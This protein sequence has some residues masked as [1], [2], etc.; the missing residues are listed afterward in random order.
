MRFMTY[1]IRRGLGADG[2]V[3]VRRIGAV[4]AAARPDVAGLNEVW[5]MTRVSDQPAR[6]ARQLGMDEVFQANVAGRF[7]RF[8]NLVLSCGTIRAGVDLKL[9]SGRE[10]RGALI[11]ETE[12]DGARVVFVTTHLGLTRNWREAQI[13]ELAAELPDDVPLVLAGDFNARFEELAPL[14]ESLQMAPTRLS[15]PSTQPRAAL[16]RLFF[17]RHWELRDVRVIRT[18]ASDHL[19][20]VADLELVAASS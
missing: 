18:L 20:L 4:I 1:N 12:V 9:S 3:S 19:P 2:A 8:G 5:Q 13:A 7:T 16:D 15:Y 17:S 10:Q 14:M 11:V 6:L